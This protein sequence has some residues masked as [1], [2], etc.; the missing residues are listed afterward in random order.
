MIRDTYSKTEPTVTKLQGGILYPYN[1]E[2]V[3]VETEEG[4]EEMFRYK[5]LKFIGNSDDISES[6]LSD[7]LNSILS[8]FKA[9][10]DIQK[11]SPKKDEW[12]NEISITDEKIIKLE[13][14]LTEEELSEILSE[15]ED[16]E[17]NQSYSIGDIVRYDSGIYQVIQS[18][19]S[20]VDWTPDV[21]PALFLE[22]SPPSVIPE[23]EQPSGA[24]DAYNTGDQVTFQGHIWES[25]IDANV[26]SPAVYPAGWEDL[27]EI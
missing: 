1:I 12:E 26:W 2:T 6:F 16:W 14:D 23:W 27:G 24:H 9:G 10:V 20:Q 8:Q 19:T 4:T 11:N 7:N 5:L 15:Y 13:K 22:I 25:L 3:E 18:H 21:V 17:T